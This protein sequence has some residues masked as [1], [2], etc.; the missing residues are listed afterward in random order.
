MAG[1]GNEHSNDLS[2]EPV[3]S[4]GIE[5]TLVPNAEQLAIIEDGGISSDLNVEPQTTTTKVRPTP[6]TISRYAL[7][8][9]SHVQP[10][11]HI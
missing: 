6:V 11:L 2:L 3:A 7:R 5:L 9:R 4:T 10:P 8:D 1:V